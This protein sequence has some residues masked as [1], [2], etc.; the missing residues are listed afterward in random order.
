VRKKTQMF[1]VSAH[2]LSRNRRITWKL[3][4]KAVVEEVVEEEAEE[5]VAGDIVRDITAVVR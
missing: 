2:I 3:E 1:C 5:E 4:E